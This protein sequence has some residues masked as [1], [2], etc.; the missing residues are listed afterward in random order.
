MSWRSPNQ[1]NV[2]GGCALANPM[3]RFKLET[4]RLGEL[5]KIT[6]QKLS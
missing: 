6:V 2:D 5:V 4:V 3:S 1:R